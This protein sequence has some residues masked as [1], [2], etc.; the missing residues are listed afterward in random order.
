MPDLQETHSNVQ[1]TASTSIST[2]P[3]D[4]LFAAADGKG[5]SIKPCVAQRL[6]WQHSS[7]AALD[8]HPAE[9][10][11]GQA[12]ET[13]FVVAAAAAAGFVAAAESVVMV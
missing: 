1:R 3:S 8:Q 12:V 13:D 5:C 11:V 6:P 10:V 9:V 7:V 2:G 4:S